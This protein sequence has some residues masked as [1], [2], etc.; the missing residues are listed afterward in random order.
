M[1]PLAM[2]ENSH[3]NI[4]KFISVITTTELYFT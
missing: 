1:E 4:R 3:K 2:P